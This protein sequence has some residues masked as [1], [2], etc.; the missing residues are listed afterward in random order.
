MIRRPGFADGRHGQPPTLAFMCPLE[1][2]VLLTALSFPGQ[3][4]TGAAVTLETRLWAVETV[5]LRKPLIAGGRGRSAPRVLLRF[6]QPAPTSTS[7]I[8]AGRPQV[9]SALGMAGE[10]IPPRASEL[11]APARPA[12]SSACGSQGGSGRNLLDTGPGEE[13]PWAP[14]P[15][16]P[17]SVLCFFCFSE[18]GFRSFCPG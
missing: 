2:T 14:S 15:S 7:G 18:T 3:E 16:F 12:L 8:S 6:P 17:V 11:A 10:Q 9:S 4:L 1:Q 13:E 5:L